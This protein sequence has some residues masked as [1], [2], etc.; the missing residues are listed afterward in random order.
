MF[1]LAFKLF[2]YSVQG[3]KEAT[4][5]KNVDL[6]LL[7]LAK[8]AS[9]IAFADKFEQEGGRLDILV[10]NAAIAVDKYKLTS[11]GWEES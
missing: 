2:A 3:I 7:D 4:G 6:W 9:V 5:F 10:A 1:L 11:D 8:F